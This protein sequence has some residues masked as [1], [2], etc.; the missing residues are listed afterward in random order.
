MVEN[1]LHLCQHLSLESCVI[2]RAGAL[3]KII[4]QTGLLSLQNF[5][6]YSLFILLTTKHRRCR[7]CN[8]ACII[9]YDGNFL[10]LL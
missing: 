7:W 3:V 8:G 10:C 1:W 6:I 4:Y 2:I 5:S 9:W